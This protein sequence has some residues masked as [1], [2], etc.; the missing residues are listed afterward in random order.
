MSGD[1]IFFEHGR[2]N[3]KTRQEESCD[4]EQEQ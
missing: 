4:N 3:Y 2:F 1:I